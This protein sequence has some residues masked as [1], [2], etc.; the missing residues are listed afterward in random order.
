MKAIVGA[1]TVHTA[2]V[3]SVITL[4]F[5]FFETIRV[6]IAAMGMIRPDVVMMVGAIWLGRTCCVWRRR[7]PSCCLGTYEYTYFFALCENQH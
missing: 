6:V 3:I 2:I 5:V 4:V 1:L 7:R